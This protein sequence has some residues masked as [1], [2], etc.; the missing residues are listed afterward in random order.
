MLENLLGCKSF[1]KIPWHFHI[2]ADNNFHDDNN[3]QVVIVHFS[4]RN[5]LAFVSLSSSTTFIVQLYSY[6]DIQHPVNFE[7]FFLALG[8]R[9]FGLDCGFIVRF[10]MYNIVDF[11]ADLE[12]TYMTPK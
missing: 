2:P 8:K 9:K 3:L 11:P 10:S 1:L 7:D 4:P 6:I 5:A 12:T